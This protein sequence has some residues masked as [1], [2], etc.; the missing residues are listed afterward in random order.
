MHRSAAGGA[1]GRAAPTCTPASKTRSSCSRTCVGKH[2]VNP[3]GHQPQ[4]HH[5]WSQSGITQKKATS[6]HTRAIAPVPAAAWVCHEFLLPSPCPHSSDGFILP[7][8]LPSP[9]WTHVHA[10]LDERWPGALETA[11]PQAVPGHPWGEPAPFQGGTRGAC[12]ARAA[13]D[14]SGQ[15]RLL[16]AP[17]SSV[18]P[19]PPA[20]Q[21]SAPVPG[22][23]AVPVTAPLGGP[24]G[25]EQLHPPLQ[26]PAKPRS[27]CPALAGGRPRP[28]LPGGCVPCGS[29]TRSSRLRTGL[30]ASSGLVP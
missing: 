16:P 15:G 13:R 19:V 27:R 14:A 1:G 21:G 24:A 5:G 12:P 23:P 25:P 30:T 29:A 3:R 2:C 17:G 18:S 20:A 6:N 7:I 28:G 8:T 9:P 4:G 26:A 22:Q 10:E 11:P